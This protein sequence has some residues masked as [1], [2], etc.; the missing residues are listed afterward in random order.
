[1]AKLF[2][3]YRFWGLIWIIVVVFV[4]FMLLKFSGFNFKMEGFQEGEAEQKDKYVEGLPSN[5]I[6]SQL[7]R[8]AAE[9]HNTPTV[10]SMSF[11]EKFKNLFKNSK[12]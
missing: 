4:V 11:G 2:K 3:N 5:S 6:Q 8:R 10:R 12:I 1:M 7:K 9:S